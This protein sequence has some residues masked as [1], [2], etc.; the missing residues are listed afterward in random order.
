[1]GKFQVVTDHFHLSL[2][3]FRIVYDYLAFKSV[4]AVCEHEADMFGG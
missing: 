3:V 1:M 2:T 4:C